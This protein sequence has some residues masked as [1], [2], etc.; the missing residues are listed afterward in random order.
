MVTMAFVSGVGAAFAA[1]TAAVEHNMPI[2]W[3]SFT[4]L[5]G[6]MYLAIGPSV[7]AVI[8]YY[9]AMNKIGAA[10]ASQYMNLIPVFAIIFGMIFLGERM[11]ASLL[12]GGGLVTLG[13][14]LAHA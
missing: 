6:L 3:G 12:L 8:F 7:I 4:F 2:P 13:L 10:R 5:S 1:I 9:Q 14:Y 11:T